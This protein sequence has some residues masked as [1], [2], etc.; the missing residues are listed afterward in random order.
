MLSIIWVITDCN[1]ESGGQVINADL[2]VV[3]NRSASPPE[4]ANRTEKRPRTFAMQAPY[5]YHTLSSLTFL[6]DYQTPKK[7]DCQLESNLRSQTR[8]ISKC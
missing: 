2:M 7:R 1:R 4:G 8:L 3:S 5:L 6:A